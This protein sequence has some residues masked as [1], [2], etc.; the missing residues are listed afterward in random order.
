MMQ[1]HYLLSNSSH[2]VVMYP[3]WFVV[4]IGQLCADRQREREMKKTLYK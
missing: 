1:C 3:W 2:P 4:L